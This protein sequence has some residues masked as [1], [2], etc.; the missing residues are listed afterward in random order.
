MPIRLARKCQIYML[1]LS[2]IWGAQPP[3]GESKDAK[4]QMLCSHM[5][6]GRTAG[7]QVLHAAFAPSGAGKASHPGK[8]KYPTAR[9]LQRVMMVI[10]REVF[11]LGCVAIF[12]LGWFRSALTY[13]KLKSF[14]VFLHNFHSKFR[15][16]LLCLLGPWDSRCSSGNCITGSHSESCS[17]WV[18]TEGLS[19]PDAGH[20]VVSVLKLSTVQHGT[21]YGETTRNY[22]PSMP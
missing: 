4:Y 7:F 12:R 9:V 15:S 17:E 13:C 20:V 16:W 21:R 14:T 19:M 10:H 1:Q 11:K 5:G 22:S 6:S 2:T 18:L 3:P 8:G